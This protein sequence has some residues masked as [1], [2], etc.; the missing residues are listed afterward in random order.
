MTA[1]FEDRGLDKYVAEGASVP[2]PVDRNKATE[3]EK[4]AVKEWEEG[5]KKAKTQIVLAVADGPLRHTAGATTARQAWTQLEAVYERSGDIGLAL[6]QQELFRTQADEGDDIPDHLS[7]LRSLHEKMGQ[8]GAAIP[9]V[10]FGNLIIMSLPKSWKNFV[11]SLLG[12]SS[13]SYKKSSHELIG[14]LTREAQRKSQDPDVAMN[15][16]GNR[17][18]RTRFQGNSRSDLECYN[19][20]KPGHTKA[21]CHAK[22]GGKE[23]QWPNKGK[24]RSNHH[25]R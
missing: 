23:G 6:T 4:K 1:I 16:K 5:D 17:G 2:L 25:M 13:G 21:N 3:D 18:K 7:K 8:L 19:C 15:V 22:G 24:S 11:D 9:D 12:S 14:I 20:H 10:N